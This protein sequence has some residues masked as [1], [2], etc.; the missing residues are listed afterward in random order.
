MNFIE[1]KQLIHRTKLQT[2]S[3]VSDDGGMGGMLNCHMQC[4]EFLPIPMIEIC[5]KTSAAIQQFEVADYIPHIEFNQS[6]DQECRTSHSFE[7]DDI[8]EDGLEMAQEMLNMPITEPN[9]ELLDD[10]EFNAFIGNNLEDP[11]NGVE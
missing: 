9:D 2:E 8:N 10:E 3:G 5:A 7:E 1:L 4:L 11:P 6:G